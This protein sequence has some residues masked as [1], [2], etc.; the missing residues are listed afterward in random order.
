MRESLVPKL[1]PGLLPEPAPALTV[2]SLVVPDVGN[3][4]N[5]NDGESGDKLCSPVYKPIFDDPLVT[6]SAVKILLITKY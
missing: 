3:A 6:S 1:Q 2:N 4:S 5:N